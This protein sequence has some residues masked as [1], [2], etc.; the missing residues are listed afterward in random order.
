MRRVTTAFL[1]QQYE[2]V[3]KQYNL[4]VKV[5]SPKDLGVYAQCSGCVGFPGR[6][7]FNEAFCKKHSIQGICILINNHS[8]QPNYRKMSTLYHE[9]GHVHCFRSGCFCQH[10]DYHTAPYYRSYQELHAMRF[11]LQLLL[12][13]RIYQGLSHDL[14]IFD[15]WSN[16]DFT[17]SSVGEEHG[18]YHKSTKMLKKSRV[19]KESKDLLDR[20]FSS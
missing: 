2:L 9:S 18:I 14:R 1:N 20:E 15:K 12:D 5:L 7:Y 16:N 13:Q 8:R 10:Q 3:A 11:A 6:G 17:E 4:Q 19:W